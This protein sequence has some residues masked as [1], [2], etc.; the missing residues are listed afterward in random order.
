MVN[1]N[2]YFTDR[3]FNLRPK[4]QRCLCRALHNYWTDIVGPS[5]KYAAGFY[6]AA[7]TAIKNGEK[8]RWHSP[9]RGHVLEFRAT[10]AELAERHV[11]A[12]NPIKPKAVAAQKATR[13]KARPS[14]APA[15]TASLVAAAAKSS[16]RRQLNGRTLH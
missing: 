3:V 5:K 15:N 6:Y 14:R 16:S 7:L 11:E 4:M 1:F 2:T 13:P 10:L 9:S 8:L 12:V